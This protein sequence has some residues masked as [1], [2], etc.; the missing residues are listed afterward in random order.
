MLRAEKKR[1]KTDFDLVLFTL[2]YILLKVSFFYN[3]EKYSSKAGLFFQ[4][5]YH[6]LTIIVLAD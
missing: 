6:Q 2:L 3:T 5:S 4:V 1:T